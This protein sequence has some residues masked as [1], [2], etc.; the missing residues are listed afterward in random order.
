MRR[1]L[2]RLVHYIWACIT[3]GG[4]GGGVGGSVFFLTF[5]REGPECGAS[6]IHQLSAAAVSAQNTTNILHSLLLRN[7]IHI[8]HWGK[9]GRE[10]ERTGREGREEKKG[11]REE[12]KE[13]E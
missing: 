11:R 8:A 3:G 10:G 6:Y 13:G 7:D 2:H 1:P 4:G 5:H 12:G 9:G